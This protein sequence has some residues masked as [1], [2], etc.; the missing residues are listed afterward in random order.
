MS[1]E[2]LSPRASPQA[3]APDEW[4]LDAIRDAARVLGRTP[5]LRAYDRLRREG[6]I[7]GPAGVTIVHRWGWAN[8]CRMAGL[9][10]NR[11]DRRFR[12]PTYSEED[13][14]AALGRVAGVVGH[15]PT[16][17]DYQAHR[18]E[19]EPS[20]HAFRLRYRGWRNARERLL[21][22]IEGTAAS[23]ESAGAPAD[24]PDPPS[25]T[26]PPVG[27]DS[28]SA[29][30]TTERTKHLVALVK[31][32]ATLAE[33]GRVYGIRRERVR[34]ILK[35][36]GISVTAL[37]D[38]NARRRGRRQA[39]RR[40]L[41]PTIEAMWD[42]GMTHDQIAAALDT[43]RKTVRELVCEFIPREER[44]ARTAEKLRDRRSPDE[45][46]LQALRDAARM[47]GRTPG[48]TAYDRLRREQLV[49]GP[50]ASAIASRWGWALACQLA[51]LTPNPRRPRTGLPTYSEDDYRSALRRVANIVGQP[52][53][54]AQY[55]ALNRDGEPSPH[56]IKRRYGGWVAARREVLPRRPPMA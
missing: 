40:G 6:R 9:P 16:L 10:P 29:P 30:S 48:Q 15:P 19:R 49:D 11:L 24:Q 56:A 31:D 55:R 36:E 18:R 38:R 50:S 5:S 21:T 13:Y 33:A 26:N 42:E 35:Q 53:T 37:P 8:A 23:N 1:P 3:R 32:G 4:F 27:T 17:A 2:Q 47:L 12:G 41:W 46:T 44:I 39:I 54:Q 45:S 43:P 7:D 20:V 51:G 25:T 22:P 28:P 14:R 34:Q 52:P